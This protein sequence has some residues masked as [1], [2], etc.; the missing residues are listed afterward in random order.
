MLPDY[1][2]FPPSEHNFFSGSIFSLLDCTFS[3]F[4]IVASSAA[5]CP[6]ANG[7][8]GFALSPTVWVLRP[9]KGVQPSPPPAPG[10]LPARVENARSFFA[11]S[12]SSVGP[13]EQP[14]KRRGPS[15]SSAPGRNRPGASQPLRGAASA[16]RGSERRGEEPALPGTREARGQRAAGREAP[17]LSHGERPSV[18]GTARPAWTLKKFRSRI[19]WALLPPSYWPQGKD[20]QVNVVRLEEL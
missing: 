1:Q 12:S 14:G 2:G 19:F 13:R 4:F 5:S 6:L 15:P 8:I 9:L 16:A 7:V 3:I 11:G 18:A 17:A 20:F 10:S